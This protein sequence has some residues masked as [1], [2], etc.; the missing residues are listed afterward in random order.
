MTPCN[1][2]SGFAQRL[3]RQM[4]RRATYWSRPA[5]WPELQMGTEVT[6]LDNGLTVVAHRDSKAP[7][8]AVYV[9]YRAGSREEPRS[10]A[11]L[12]HLFEHLMFS[13]TEKFPGNAL[14]SSGKAWC[15]FR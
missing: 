15:D 4:R 7:I 13:G 6:V 2:D 12:A 1:S 11:G 14:F 9:A 8:V 3:K 5:S 10:K